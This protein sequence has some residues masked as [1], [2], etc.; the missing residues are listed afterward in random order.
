MRT[1]EVIPILD[2]V[3]VKKNIVRKMSIKSSK[4]QKDK[5]YKQICTKEQ[6]PSKHQAEIESEGRNKQFN[7]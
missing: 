6:R 1:G 3:Y 2:K 7:N 4:N 5:N